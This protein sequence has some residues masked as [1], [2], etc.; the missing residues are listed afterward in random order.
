VSTSA[1]AAAEPVT[2]ERPRSTAAVWLGAALVST[3]ALAVAA[4]NHASP[5]AVSPVTPRGGWSSVWP[6]SVLAA[7]VL[8]G[9][10]VLA[11]RDGRLRLRVAVAVAIGV[12]ALPLA[13]PLLLSKD[14]FGYWGEA[15][16]LLVHHANPYEATPG[17]FPGDLALPWVSQ[18]WQQAHS[19]YGPVWQVVGTAPA[20]VAGDSRLAAEIAYRVLAA[21]AVLAC[22]WIVARRTGDAAAVAFLGW[23]PLV[24]LHYAG[25]GHLDAVMMALA[26]GALAA[27]ATARGGA[28]WPLAGA[29]KPVPLVLLPL[30]LARRRLAVGRRWW[31]GLAGSAVAVAAVSTA[32]F[33]TRWVHAA[34]AGLHQS[35][36]LGGVHWLTEHGLVH[37]DAV[38]VAGGVF[39]VVY[40]LLLWNAWRTGRGRLSLAAT[41]LCLCSSLLRP[42]YALWPVALAAF[43]EDA[44]GAVAAFALSAYVLFGDAVKF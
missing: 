8:Y 6:W 32:L 7:F 43:E 28:L 5:S 35:S 14:V 4:A 29:V 27:G 38:L 33:G 30:E 34:V 2:R 44:I 12:Q 9:A 16:V 23:S 26:L 41:A 13:A 18:E 31:I 37:R 39:A 1:V 21:A 19:P 11:A 20:L 36:P 17:S 42:W 22:V 25:G 3:V 24:A 40:A 15:R 10:G